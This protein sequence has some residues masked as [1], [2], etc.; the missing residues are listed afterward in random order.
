MNLIDLRQHM[1]IDLL[2]VVVFAGAPAVL[3]LEGAAAV[4]SYVLAAVHLLMTLVTAS[5]PWSA[6]GLIP[7]A[8]HGLVEAGVG[9][10]LALLG[11]LAFDGVAGTFY[12]VMGAVIVAV[13]VITPYLP[14]PAR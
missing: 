1:V 9:V 12:V 6:A 13:F 4:L 7:L 8:L 3:G 11:V 10:A 2:A 5:L 14:R